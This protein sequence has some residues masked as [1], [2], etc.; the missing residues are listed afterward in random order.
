MDVVQILTD[1]IRKITIGQGGA[2]V[3]ELKGERIA[4]HIRKA[5]LPHEQAWEQYMTEARFYTHASA[6]ER[7]FMP[8]ILRCEWTQEEI[9]IVMRKYRPLE[10][11]RL[12]AGMLEKALDVLAQIHAMPLAEDDARG[13]QKAQYLGE[14][15]I[16]QCRS[17]W[18]SVLAEHGDAFEMAA[19]DRIAEK[20]NDI[21]S[22]MYSA[23][24]CCC[25]GDFHA[26]NLLVDAEDNI[27]VCDW[28]NVGIEHPAG[29]IAFLLSRLAADGVEVDRAEA[30]DMY[31][32]H[33][34]SDITA[35]EIEA[36]MR[37][38]NLNTSF[39]FWHHYL[40][41]AAEAAARGIFSRMIEDMDYLVY[42]MDDA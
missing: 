36:Q 13:D 27:I 20:I 41:G 21:N 29:D 1:A 31:C 15:E 32:R 11:K 12:N 19:L 9:L 40:H 37:L 16:E 39:V 28:Q 24:R 5:N 23:R 38:A 6:K 3:Y 42:D 17:G 7:P 26:D 35:A 4:K 2:D 25:H 30:V 33:A 8:E 14:T 34:Q 22:R 18:R 10:R